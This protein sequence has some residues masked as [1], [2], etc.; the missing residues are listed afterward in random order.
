[1]ILLLLAAILLVSGSD[2]AWADPISGLIV[3]AIGLGGLG[4][5][6]A[7][8]TAVVDIGLAV[9]LS[10]AA[11]ALG[12]KPKKGGSTRGQSI[13]LTIDAS[14]YR[15]FPVGE[16]G[17]G[18][19]LVY[20]QLYGNNN[21]NLQMVIALGDIECDSLSSTIFVNSKPQTIDES[22]Y[23]SGFSS[24][25]K[26][27]FHNGSPSQSADS[28]VSSASSGRW[29][30]TEVGKHVCYAV[31]SCQYDE[32]VFQSGIPQIVFVLKGA[33]LY[34]WRKDSTNGGSGS[35]RWNDMSTWAF[36]DNPI[37]VLYNVLRGVAPGGV[38][39]IGMRVPAAALRLADFTA[40]AN[41]CDETI[42]LA[43]GGTEKRYRISAV[44][45]TSMT[46]RDIIETILSSCAGELVESCGIYRPMVGVAQTSVAD[47]TDADL[48]VDQPFQSD[49]KRPRSELTNAVY[50]TF[51]DP[52]RSYNEVPLP[53]RTSS[54]DEAED[55]GVRL[56]QTL[57]LTMVTSR[58]QAQRLMEIARKR[59]RRQLVVSLTLRSR[60]FVLEPGD[61]V[62]FNSDRRGYVDR[63]F[64]VI[65]VKV[66]RD[67]TSVVTLR[68][69]DAGIDDWSTSD[70]LAD[71]QATDL[72]SAGPGF[73]EVTGLT[74]TPSVYLG[75][76]GAQIPY[77]G[78]EWD[79]VTDPTV[80]SL[81]L[82]YRKVG[83]TVAVSETI[84]DP[85]SG[86]VY[87]ATKG[88]QGNLSYEARV[89]P[90]TAPERAVE[91]T[92]WVTAT[93]NSPPAIIDQAAIAIAVPP[94]TI[95]PGMLDAQ[96]RFMLSLTVATEEVIGSLPQQ[97]REVKDKLKA[98][99][100]A[101]IRSLLAGAQNKAD[102][103]LEKIVRKS[104]TEAF[105]QQIQTIETT[106]NE[107]VAAQITQEITARSTADSALASQIDTVS[108]ALGENI[109]TVSVL[110][111][112]VDGIKSQFTV[113]LNNNGNVIG[114]VDL[115][116]ENGSASFTVEAAKFL[117]ALTGT[118]GGM[119]V[120]VFSIQNVN[121]S[122]KLAL[123][124]DMIADGS[125]TA[126]HISAASIATLYISDPANTYFWDFANGRDGSTDGK[127][128]IDR[129]NKVID[130]TF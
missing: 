121:G 66:Q 112:S 106:L 74:V 55:G 108:S 58:T 90:V 53:N 123:R 26:I 13:N 92:S 73:S 31:V 47:L 100:E 30:S 109:S 82:E 97:V 52:T 60:W 49:P 85:Q 1:M 124:G 21:D 120:P 87:A 72:A 23:V 107:T 3:G 22:G 91:W 28:A 114:L 59:A 27:T 51:A 19:D 128:L 61:W 33:K 98:S 62:T 20:W 8:A 88:I 46:N 18:G 77:L 15:K 11:K 79:P 43:A 57:D 65:S 111:T 16:G 76:G 67:L 78:I 110:A 35:Q 24:K 50:G 119:A 101:T 83:D 5:T 102:I 104:Q 130:I 56:P 44:F 80:I 115:S 69:T 105:A 113:A 122:P 99:S 118:P 9:G 39:L 42:S 37:V 116:G 32:K 7:I 127:F 14:P 34:D 63:T 86:G 12:P 95:T 54:D 125:I 84:L 126:A 48:I 89:R 25:L 45:D 2:G 94:D 36:S 38:P 129:K 10:Y 6:T 71:N 81:T 117:V 103:R 41:A 93:D 17:T 29:G 4:A 75:D 96:S 64:E 70:E 68:E 40:A